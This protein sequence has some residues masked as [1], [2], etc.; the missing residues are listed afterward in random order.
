VRAKI[1]ERAKRRKAIE[2]N[3]DAGETMKDFGFYHPFEIVEMVYWAWKNSDYK[4]MPVE[5]GLMDQP[6]ALMNDLAVYS[7]LFE[8]EMTK[9][10]AKDKK[11]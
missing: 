6:I 3:Q 5:G 9:L 8:A 10:R 1:G 4:T 2:D 7:E 11:Q